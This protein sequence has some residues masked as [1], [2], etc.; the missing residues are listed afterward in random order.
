ML[1]LL[2]V[3]N[4][5]S[6]TRNMIQRA[7]DVP[8]RIT[9]PEVHSSRSDYFTH[10]NNWFAHFPSQN[11]LIMDY[12]EI[13]INPRDFLLKIVQHIGLGENE[14]K[15]YVENLSDDDVKQ[16]VN[17]AT[18]AQFKTKGTNSATKTTAAQS[19]QY[20]LSQRPLLK[21]QMEVML[22]PYAS[23]FNLLLKEQGYSWRLDEYTG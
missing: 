10:L 16:R 13:D 19:S 6:E 4:L 1:E 8:G 22:R 17:A 7:V 15:A 23:K 9:P 5:A 21:K 12:R 2:N 3:F 11:V 14:S 18:D 20:S